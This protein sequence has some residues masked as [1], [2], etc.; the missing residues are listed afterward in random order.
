MRPTILASSGLALLL[1]A[2]GG[3]G[4]AGPGA[5]AGVDLQL[6]C[7]IPND[8]IF[9][10]GPGIDGIPALHNPTLVQFGDPTATYLR[11]FDRVMGLLIAGAPVAVPLNIL[12]WHEIVNLDVAGLS[13]AVTHCPLTGS[14][15]VFDRGVIGER[16]LGV[17]G[18]LYQNNLLMYDRDEP[19]SL[20]PQMLRG[21]R[22]GRRTG[23]DL[24][25]YPSI[26]MTWAGWRSL[27][28]NTTVVSASTGYSRD[29]QRYPYGS[30]DQ[31]NNRQLLF[32]L[33]IDGRRPPKERVLGIPE[34]PTGGIAIPFG[35]LDALGALAA[36]SFVRDGQPFV[37]FWDRSTWT[38]MAFR[39]TA[40]GQSLAFDVVDE[41]IVDT[42][43]G[44]IWQVDGLATSGQLAGE[45]LE[46]IADAFVAFWFAWAEFYPD[47]EL[48]RG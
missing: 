30:Y 17:S 41:R 13:L 33:P 12:W 11:D 32:P 28:P 10:G 15:L 40:R 19:I 16:T 21:A 29:Y 4:A 46:P 6:T 48:W 1:A 8:Q 37:V 2:C 36:V 5:L 14:S 25:M 43:T 24:P 39:T 26:E 45:R 23:T 22:C 34:D 27:H 42:E 31:P 47:A 7:T 9:P 44:S 20:W 38:A 35:A 18:L 3:D